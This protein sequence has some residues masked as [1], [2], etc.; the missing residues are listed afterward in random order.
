MGEEDA[1]TPSGASPLTLRSVTTYRGLNAQRQHVFETQTTFQAWAYEVRLG[2]EDG[3]TFRAELLPQSSR[4]GGTFLIRPDGLLASSTDTQV[5]RLR[6]T[7]LGEDGQEVAYV[8]R[9]TQQT[10]LRGQ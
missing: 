10:T 3:Q 8:L 4:T 2:G 5:L 9:V 7:A 1:F 6:V